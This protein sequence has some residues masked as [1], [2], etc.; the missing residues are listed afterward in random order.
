MGRESSAGIVG[1][2]EGTWRFPGSGVEE[3]E[4]VR[5]REGV[6]EGNPTSAE[7]GGDRFRVIDGVGYVELCVWVT[8]IAGEELK[9]SVSVG[10]TSSFLPLHAANNHKRQRNHL[11]L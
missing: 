11:L 2:A 6:S 7:V 1:V 10:Y 4:V 8:M 5:W 9:G 3:G